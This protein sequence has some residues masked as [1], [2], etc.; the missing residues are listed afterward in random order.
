[1]RW[2]TSAAAG[3]GPLAIGA[4]I[5][6]A[7]VLAG[8]L[9]SQVS[10]VRAQELL[11]FA[12]ASLKNALDEVVA[13]HRTRT[14]T[15]VSVSYAGSAALAKQIENGAPAGLFV[16]ASTD[17]MDYLEARQAIRP[18]TRIDL[19]GNRLVLIAPV[20]TAISV[21]PVPGL[22]LR[23]MIGDGRLAMADPDAVPA[24]M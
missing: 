4:Y 8:V 13:I 9:A 17:W 15:G 18:E 5:L 23:R 11:V 7:F 10:T 6:A 16:S 22:P 3:S 20:R 2:Y 1:I 19:L 21:D 24:G 12:A 14:G